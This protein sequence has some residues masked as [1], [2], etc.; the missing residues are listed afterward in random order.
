M[1][2][3][4]INIINVAR[5]PKNKFYDSKIVR[6]RPFGRPMRIK[7]SINKCILS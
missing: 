2:I 5:G 6:D 7:S 1:C 4:Y 3:M